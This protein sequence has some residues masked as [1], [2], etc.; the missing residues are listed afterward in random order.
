MYII[1]L[2]HH[3]MK[4]LEE[5][6]NPYYDAHQFYTFIGRISKYINIVFITTIYSRV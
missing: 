5:K 2:Y 3:C 4:N 6:L 1:L